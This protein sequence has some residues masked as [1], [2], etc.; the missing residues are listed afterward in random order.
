MYI[1]LALFVISIAV[2][3]F[4]IVFDELVIA[5]FARTIKILHRYE[6]G[7]YSF[8]EKSF[9]IVV[10]IGF[11]IVDFISRNTVLVITFRIKP[12]LELITDFIGDVTEYPH[13]YE[14]WQVAIAEQY[15]VGIIEPIDPHHF[16]G[17][18][19]NGIRRLIVHYKSLQRKQDE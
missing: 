11:G 16:E 4:M 2:A 12:K 13:E 3:I 18:P 9:W 14:P 15:R 17:R 1:L 19:N 6:R 8:A 7:D 5:W 10:A